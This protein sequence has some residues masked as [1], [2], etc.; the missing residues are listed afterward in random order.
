MDYLDRINAKD[1]F[2]ALVSLMYSSALDLSYSGRT[3]HNIADLE[4]E[5]KE[6]CTPVKPGLSRVSHIVKGRRSYL[7]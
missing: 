5:T 6:Y 4:S 1:L 7:A 2:D 3:L